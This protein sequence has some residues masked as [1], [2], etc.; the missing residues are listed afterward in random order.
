MH[1]GTTDIQ[2]NDTDFLRTVYYAASLYIFID[3]KTTDIG[4]DR[5]VENLAEFRQLL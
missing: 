4:N 1:I 2:L 3:R 5:F